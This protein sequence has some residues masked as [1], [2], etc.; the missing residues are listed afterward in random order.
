M[1]MGYLHVQLEFQGHGEGGVSKEDRQECES[2][3]K[4]MTL[5]T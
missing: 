3:N 4:L 2:T 1:H 5:L